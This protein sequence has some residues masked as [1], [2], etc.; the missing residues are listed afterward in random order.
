M[1][2]LGDTLIDAAGKTTPT[3][4]LA[5][6]EAVGIYFS[7]HGCP[8]CKGFTPKLAETYKKLQA[9][10]PGAF[11]VVFVS[12]DRD[13][14]QFDE[15]LGEM[16][17]KALPY[18]DRDTKAAL[19]KKY[20]VRGIPTFVVVDA[21]TGETITTEG[22]EAVGSDPDGESFPW[23]PP[24]FAEALG[25]DFLKTS[26][27]ALVGK[28][29]AL[30]FSAHWCPPCK[31]FTPQ[32]VEVYNKMKASGRDDFE[33]IF[34]SGDRDQ[35]QFDEYFG[36]MPWAAVPYGSKAIDK[37]NARFGIRGIPALVTVDENGN[38]INESA[39][40]AVGSDKEGQNFPWAPPLVRSIEEPDGINETPALC[41]LVD[42]VAEDARAAA[43]AAMNEVAREAQKKSEGQ[44]PE[45]L[46][47]EAT[48]EDGD[49][50]PQI[51]SM[52][53]I[54]DSS[55]PALV[56]LDI[57]DDG[58]FYVAPECPTT[59]AGITAFVDGCKKKEGRQQLEK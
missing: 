35:K 34:V 13:Q 17:W 42:G 10:K 48:E 33:F 52:V 59:V 36:E 55:K 41:L 14:K 45:L 56:L 22:R 54:T 29:L 5:S 16:P 32:L 50:C 9:S 11:E 49:V 39:R 31:R 46:F 57:P 27:E 43:R 26:P 24:T 8:P 40:G 1:D 19:S 47:F 7:A 18:S 44:E 53:K 15:Y 51:R 28:K 4:S 58:G 21:K 37:L 30:Y 20:K 2:M 25:S 3:S 6:C 38:T 23:T 12:S